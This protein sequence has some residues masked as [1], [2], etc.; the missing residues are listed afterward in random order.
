M[1]QQLWDV[2]L[3]IAGWFKELD[4]LDSADDEVRKANLLREVSASELSF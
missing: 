3:N 4:S 1:V 2:A